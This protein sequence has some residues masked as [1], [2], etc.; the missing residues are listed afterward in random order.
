MKPGRGLASGLQAI[1]V[2]H[3]AALIHL[4]SGQSVPISKKDVK[5]CGRAVCQPCGPDSPGAL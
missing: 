4:A 3:K 5:P 1:N 2:L